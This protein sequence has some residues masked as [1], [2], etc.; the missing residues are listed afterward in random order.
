MSPLPC[1]DLASGSR[2]GLLRWAQQGDMAT[3]LCHVEEGPVWKHHRRCLS[4]K[5]TMWWGPSLSFLPAFYHPWMAEGPLSWDNDNWGGL[6]SSKPLSLL[7]WALPGQGHTCPSMTYLCILPLC[8][9]ATCPPIPCLP[10][11]YGW[12]QQHSGVPYSQAG[13]LISRRTEWEY[14]QSTGLIDIVKF[15]SFRDWVVAETVKTQNS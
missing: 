10:A 6:T 8:Q 13:A 2:K 5:F 12:Q 11:N 9:A 7:L 14:N 15:F 3:P 4:S 1:Q